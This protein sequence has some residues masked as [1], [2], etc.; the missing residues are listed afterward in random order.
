MSTE[1]GLFPRT[2]TVHYCLSFDEFDLFAQVS[3]RAAHRPQKHTTTTVLYVWELIEID[4][5]SFLHQRF[6]MNPE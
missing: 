2:L 5:H 4:F 6:L 3:S 1:V